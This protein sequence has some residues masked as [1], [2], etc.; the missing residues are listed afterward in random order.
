LDASG[1]WSRPNPLG[2]AGL[3]APGESEARAA[4]RITAPLPDVTGRDRDRFAGRHA[5]A[6]G[7]GHSAA[8]TL[9][10]LAALAERAPGTRISWAVRSADVSRVYGG[11][12]RDELAAR[13]ALGTRLR[14]LV[15]TGT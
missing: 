5:L 1:T 7:A 9:L 3:A 2:Q 12:D 14:H 13:G 8:N 6:V 15:E 11:G 10:D 4:G